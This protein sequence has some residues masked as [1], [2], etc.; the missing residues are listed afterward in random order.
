MQSN[1]I[2]LPSERLRATQGFDL[3][4]SCKKGNT[5]RG[6]SLPCDLC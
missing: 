5:H 4:E 1:M 6:W 3:E 2:L